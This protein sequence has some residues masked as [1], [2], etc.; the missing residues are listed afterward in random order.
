MTK[1]DRNDLRKLFVNLGVKKDK[2]VMIHG[3]MP[4]CGIIDGGYETFFS[5]LFELVGTGGGVIVPTFTYSFTKGEV[6]DVQ[7]TKS[8]VGDFTNYF[9]TLDDCYRNLEPNFSMAGVGK[10]IQKIICRNRSLTFGKNSIYEKIEEA[11]VLFLLLGIN[12]DQGLSYFMHLEA[13]YGVEYR[14]NK[15]FDGETIDYDR[16]LIK[17]K[18]THF[19]RNID[20]NPIQ[21][22]TRLGEYLEDNNIA[23]TIKF[24]YGLHRSIGAKIL[25]EEVFK[26]L[27]ENKYYLLKEINKEVVD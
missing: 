12:W 3:F 1:V 2:I 19:V 9:L 5:V 23:K 21:Y 11:D 8:T 15:V 4:S 25:K 14:Y 17:D 24:G 20:M 18:A 6:Y 10:N 16:R 26:K 22:R 7:N 13:S 27:K